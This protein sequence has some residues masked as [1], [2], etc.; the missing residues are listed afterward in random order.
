MENGLSKKKILKIGT[1]SRWNLILKHIVFILVVVCVSLNL[2][3]EEPKGN[4]SSFS[5]VRPSFTYLNGIGDK[6]YYQDLGVTPLGTIYVKERAN[7]ILKPFVGVT[8]FGCKKLDFS[9]WISPIKCDEKGS[10]VVIGASFGIN[11]ASDSKSVSYMMGVTIGYII[12]PDWFFGITYGGFY[13][14]VK[15]MPFPYKENWIHPLVPVGSP[16]SPLYSGYDIPTESKMGF[17]HGLGFTLGK[18]IEFN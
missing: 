18:K 3:A 11:E 7:V 12:A 9:S 8:F 4:E 14:K 10:S 5:G 2:H 1:L 6:S 17:F 13:D 15:T 16:V